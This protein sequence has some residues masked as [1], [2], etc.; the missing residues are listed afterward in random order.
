[1]SRNYSRISDPSLAYL[2]LI[3]DS[4]NSDW[5]L[6]TFN[7]VFTL[8]SESFMN[9]MLEPDSQYAAPALDDQNIQ[10]NSNNH[11]THLILTPANTLATLTITLPTP[12][13]LRDKQLLICNCTQQVTDL[14]IEGN[15]AAA[16]NGMPSS[17]GADDFFTLKY[18]LT[19]NTWN[20]VG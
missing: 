11:D 16:V 6:T 18:D 14:T 9:T 10:I 15:G 8:F 20:R 1:M 4:S 3:W 17:L 2:S 13:N 19:L 7:D 12:A 5:R